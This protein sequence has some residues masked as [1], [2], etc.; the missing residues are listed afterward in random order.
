MLHFVKG[1]LGANAASIMVVK[2]YGLKFNQLSWYT[3]HIIADSSS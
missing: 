3:P 1:E 2:V